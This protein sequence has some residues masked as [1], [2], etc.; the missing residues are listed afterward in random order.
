M[1][2]LE[3][4]R[5]K[6]YL[7]KANFTR[8]TF[9]PGRSLDMSN[10]DIVDKT[11]SHEVCVCC[12]FCRCSCTACGRDGGSYGRNV[13]TWLNPFG[14]CGCGCGLKWWGNSYSSRMKEGARGEGKFM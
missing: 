2:G 12:R 14:R 5:E 3:I 6:R 11:I 8:R 13:G 9:R 7:G 4:P 10:P 1:I